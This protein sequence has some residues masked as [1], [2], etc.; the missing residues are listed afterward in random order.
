MNSRNPDFQSPGHDI[1]DGYPFNEIVTKVNFPYRMGADLSPEGRPF[2]VVD[3]EVF[4][5]CPNYGDPLTMQ[6]DFLLHRVIDFKKALEIAEGQ[7]QDLLEEHP[8]IPEEMNF[9]LLA[10]NKEIT[11]PPYRVY[12]PKYDPDFSIYR[13]PQ[14]EG[15][16]WDPALWTINMN[17]GGKLIE[18]EFKLPC[19]RIA[20]AV[21]YSLG[22]KLALPEEKEGAIA[23]LREETPLN[24]DLYL[25]GEEENHQE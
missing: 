11:D 14:E 23:E 8:F 21:F 9:E 18:M 3:K 1:H 2:F 5:D 16:K 19:R 15:K 20:Y 24:R 7:I 17:K 6:E 13:K 25:S 10:K 12:G 4:E 22:I